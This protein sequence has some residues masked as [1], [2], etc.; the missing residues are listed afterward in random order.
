MSITAVV[1]SKV[2]L[3]ETLTNDDLIA[4]SQLVHSG[5]DQNTTLS[6]STSPD[7][8]KAAYQTIALVAGAKTID[9]TALLLNGNAVTLD[10]LNPRAI[11]LKNTGAAAMTIV[12][13]AS[14]G[15]TGLGALF[16][17]TLPPDAGFLMD[18]PL[19]NATAVSATVKTLDVTGTGTDTLQLSILAGT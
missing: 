14:N 2:T 17:V 8:T 6:G 3:T 1:Q 4:D 7:I 13:G 19:D 9:L 18:W 16:S 15:Y 10:G 11:H 12:A 5:Y